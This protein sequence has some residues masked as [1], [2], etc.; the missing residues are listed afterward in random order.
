MSQDAPEV[1]SMIKLK[2]VYEPVVPSDGR[3]FLVD[4]IWPRGVRKEALSIDVWLKEVG[5]SNELRKWFGHDPSRWTE[6]QQRYWHE[7]EMHPG[8]LE[9]LLNAARQSDIT[10]VYSARDQQH[11]QAVVI[12]DYLECLIGPP[13]PP[14][15]TTTPPQ[16]LGETPND[17]LHDPEFKTM[18][19]SSSAPGMPDVAARVTSSKPSKARADSHAERPRKG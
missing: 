7:L 3:R 15:Q 10:L 1:R 16:S 5:P 4:R 18:P 12:K 2:R 8:V 13:G 11:N 6:F 19:G 14:R 9:P 17:H